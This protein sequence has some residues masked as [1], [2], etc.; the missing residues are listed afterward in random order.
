[1]RKRIRHYEQVVTEAGGTYLTIS[2]RSGKYYLVFKTRQ[3]TQRK[4]RVP[5]QTDYRGFRNAET[6]IRRV[7]RTE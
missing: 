5:N 4:M 1:M 3:G 2:E 6:T 7:V